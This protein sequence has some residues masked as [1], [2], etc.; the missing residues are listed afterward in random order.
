MFETLPTITTRLLH[1]FDTFLTPAEPDRPDSVLGSGRSL[2]RT[3][4][5]N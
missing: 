2:T 5:N 3:N 1:A 4:T